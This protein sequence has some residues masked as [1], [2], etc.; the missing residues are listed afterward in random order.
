[1]TTWPGSVGAGLALA[2]AGAGGSAAGP[3]ARS[4]SKGAAY[5]VC[6]VRPAMICGCS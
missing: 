2:L 4:I 1:M 5:T 3:A 6:E